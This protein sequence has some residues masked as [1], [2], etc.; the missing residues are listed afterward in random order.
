MQ[1][2]D[3]TSEMAVPDLVFIQMSGA[4]GSG[5]TTLAHAIAG[6]IGALVIDHD[7]TKSALLA[8]EVPVAIAGRASYAVLDA[9]ARHLLA[10]RHSVI[11]DS[12][13]FYEELLERGQRLAQQAG[14]Q[15]R[16]IECVV[17]DLDELDRRLRT[18]PRLPSQVAG[19]W[20]PPTGG[21][22]KV[23]SG[24]EVFRDWIANM[25]R[26]ES[27]YLVLDTTRPLEVCL[28]EALAYI[29]D[30]GTK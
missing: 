9:L 12:P 27:G 1:P 26:P 4:P 25:K 8:A 17:E 16:Y 30:A 14:A 10:Q 13:C 22:G 6:R 18:R 29:S 19:V 3:P 21:S 24:D 7:V 5:K 11:F 20:A 15:Y 23:L 28:G 2:D